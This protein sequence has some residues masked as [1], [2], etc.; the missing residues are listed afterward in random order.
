MREFK[1]PAILAVTTFCLSAAFI[2]SAAHGEALFDALP[3][4]DAP[5]TI[6]HVREGLHA[7]G[8]VP[9]V[10]IID[11][12]QI[13]GEAGMHRECRGTAITDAGNRPVT[14]EIGWHDA[15]NGVPYFRGELSE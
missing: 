1:R 4:C 5:M 8:P 10:E 3:R 12:T 7:A 11:V 2:V 9:V 13:G 14:F 15:V 6:Y